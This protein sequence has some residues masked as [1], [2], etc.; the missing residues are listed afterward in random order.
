MPEFINISNTMKNNYNCARIE[1]TNMS[2]ELSNAL[3]VSGYPTIY[4]FDQRG[5]I[6]GRYYGERT[7]EKIMNAMCDNYHFCMPK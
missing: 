5:K 4:F 1:R 6:L 3:N 2:N 7:V